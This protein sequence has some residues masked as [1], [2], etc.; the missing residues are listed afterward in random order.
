[1]TFSMYEPMARGDTDTICALLKLYRK[2]YRI[3]GAAVSTLGLAVTPFLP[4]MIRGE[5]PADVSLYALYLINLAN[6]SCSY[7]LFG[8][9]EALL[10]ADQRSDI[11]SLIGTGVTV[12][13]NLLQIFLLLWM[14]SY[15]MYCVLIPVVYGCQKSGGL[16]G[17]KPVVSAVRMSGSAGSHRK[18]GHYE[19]G[20]RTAVLQDQRCIPKLR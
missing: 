5:M 14:K 9:R 18:K 13:K 11:S 19:A 6:V 17:D 8:Y 1:M 3:I 10:V 4:Y 16:R 12:F 15:Y 2:I 20:H 7:F